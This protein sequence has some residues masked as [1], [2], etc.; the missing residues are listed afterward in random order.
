MT[1]ANVSRALL[2][3]FLVL[4]VTH[5]SFVQTK[6][7]PATKDMW[8][9]SKYLDT[10]GT[11]WQLRQ[12]WSRFRKGK[13][14]ISRLEEEVCDVVQ[15]S[16]LEFNHALPRRNFG[17]YVEEELVHHNFAAPFVDEEWLRD[18]LLL[19]DAVV[20]LV[21]LAMEQVFC[22]DMLHDMLHDMLNSMAA[23][24]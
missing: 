1:S 5:G 8:Y 3:N 10:T 24:T 4:E 9:A 11:V 15:G 20:H 17:E 2:K 16:H 14:S 12:F 23:H 13:E 6:G 7:A 21:C 19:F 22:Y 18:M